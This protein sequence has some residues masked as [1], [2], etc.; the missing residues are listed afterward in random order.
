MIIRVVHENHFTTIRN[1][2]V[3]DSRLSFKARGLLIYLLSLPDD[4]RVSRD[5]LTTVGPDGEKAIRSALAELTKAGYL[6]REIVSEGRG[7]VRTVTTLRERPRPAEGVSSGR[8]Q[9]SRTTSDDGLRLAG[10]RP[11]VKPATLR[12]TKEGTRRQRAGSPPPEKYLC[13]ACA[14]TATRMAMDETWWC[15]EHRAEYELRSLLPRA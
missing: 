3:R 1:K 2:T 15:D 8:K 10:F 6:T 4:A 5:F 9:A 12:S 7:R 11:G 13:A 14:R